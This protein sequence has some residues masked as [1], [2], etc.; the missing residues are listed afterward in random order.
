VGP[1][2]TFASDILACRLA[3]VSLPSCRGLWVSSRWLAVRPGWFR[4]CRSLRCVA[5]DCRAGLALAAA[6]GRSGA[7]EQREG[8]QAHEAAPAVGG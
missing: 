2:F 5:G 1:I 6:L 4:A 8:F 7:G 3:S